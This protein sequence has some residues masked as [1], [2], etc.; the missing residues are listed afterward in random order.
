VFVI[1]VINKLALEMHILVSVFGELGFGSWNMTA[2]I[3]AAD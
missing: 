1:T 2:K 3:L